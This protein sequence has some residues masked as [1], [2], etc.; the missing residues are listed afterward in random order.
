MIKEPL[1]PASLKTFAVLSLA[2]DTARLRLG[3]RE[4]LDV[5][6][7]KEIWVAFAIMGDD[8]ACDDA[9]QVCVSDSATA[10]LALMREVDFCPGD[11]RHLALGMCLF[12]ALHLRG[13]S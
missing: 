13:C 9:F 8:D 12:A 5:I 11:T 6:D 1:N 3:A 10:V 7:E 2:L 4:D